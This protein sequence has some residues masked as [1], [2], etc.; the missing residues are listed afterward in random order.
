VVTGDHECGYFTGPGS[1]PDWKPIVN[2]GKGQMPGC[3]FHSTGHTNQLIPLFV[4]GAGADRFAAIADEQDKRRGA[5]TDN[6]E[7][8]GLMLELLE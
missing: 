7:V 8:G 5:Y 4:K 1:D 2:N 3:E 6:A